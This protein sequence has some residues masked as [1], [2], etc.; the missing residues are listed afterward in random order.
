MT[1]FTPQEI[2]S[3]QG[4]GNEV[5][6]TSSGFIVRD[7]SVFFHCN[8][9]IISRL[10]VPC[11]KP[12]CSIMK[13]LSRGAICRFPFQPA[14]CEY[15]SL[16]EDLTPPVLSLTL[17]DFTFNLRIWPILGSLMCRFQCQLIR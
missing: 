8:S 5:R 16:V 13:R 14:L 4:T 1:S 7:D 11:C 3:L 17:L 10:K 6:F 2:E 9:G 12:F 15:L